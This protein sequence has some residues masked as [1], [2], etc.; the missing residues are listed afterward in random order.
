MEKVHH[1]TMAHYVQIL[2]SLYPIVLARLP[3]LFSS[4]KIKL[5]Q[6][7]IRINTYY[8]DNHDMN[9]VLGFWG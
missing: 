7:Y 3:M 5:M 2:K 6:N 4:L 1:S 9:G 8:H